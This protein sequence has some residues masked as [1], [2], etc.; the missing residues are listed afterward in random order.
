MEQNKK[1]S[2]FDAFFNILKKLFIVMIILSIVPSMFSGMKTNIQD[3][4]F[5]KTHVGLININGFIGDSTYYIKKIEEFSKDKD[6]KGLLLKINSPGGYSGSSQAIFN[7]LKRFKKEKPIVALIENAGASGA[8]YIAMAA[9]TI[10]ASPIS[11]VGSIGVF[12]EL[13]NVKELLQNWKVS[14]KYVQSGTYK[15]TG[16]AVKELT[17]KEFEYLQQLTDDQYE[18]FIHDVAESR[19]LSVKDHQLWADGKAFTG[20]QALELK[21]IDKLGSYSDALDEVK[22]LTKSDVE[23]KLIQPK[24]ASN[25]MRL[26]G[27]DDNF[28]QDSISLSDYFASFLSSVFEKVSVTQTQPQPQLI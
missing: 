8:Y 23:I 9:D 7:E 12:M 5:P 1:A 6:I 15:T 16:S 28:G 4:M 24:R 13:P 27:G 22:K 3:A 18:Q 11:I 20:N 2:R 10:I 21:L 25:L 19:K 17:E 14:Y 26:L